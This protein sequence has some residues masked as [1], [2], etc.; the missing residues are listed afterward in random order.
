MIWCHLDGK[1]TPHMLC[2][3]HVILDMNLDDSCS[4]L[5]RDADPKQTCGTNTLHLAQRL[6]IQ[7]E[8]DIT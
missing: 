3:S 4:A 2:L 5:L 6:V 8:L 1:N 7:I